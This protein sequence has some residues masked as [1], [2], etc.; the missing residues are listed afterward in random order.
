MGRGGGSPASQSAQRHVGSVELAQKGQPMLSGCGS[1]S[2]SQ[3]GA[4]YYVGPTSQRSGCGS[5]LSWRML[6]GRKGHPALSGWEALSLSQSLLRR[7]SQP[8][9]RM[10]ER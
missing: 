2:L 9:L 5:V 1:M 8:A 7:A 4:W 6:L 3:V 10:W